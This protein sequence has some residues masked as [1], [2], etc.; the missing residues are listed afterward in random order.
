MR[1]Y[2]LAL[3][4]DAACP[5]YRNFFHTKRMF[6]PLSSNEELLYCE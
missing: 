3:A 2:C 4:F 6:P 5:D 1:A